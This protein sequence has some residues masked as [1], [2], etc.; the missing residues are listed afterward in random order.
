MV[1]V[2]NKIG[3]KTD[4][5]LPCEICRQFVFNSDSNRLHMKQGEGRFTCWTFIDITYFYIIDW[6]TELKCTILIYKCK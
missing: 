5:I 2:I 6:L 4:S 3:N 1:G